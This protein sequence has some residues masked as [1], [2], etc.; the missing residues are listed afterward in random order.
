MSPRVLLQSQVLLT[1]LLAMAG[2]AVL[3]DGVATAG[4]TF[5]S[6]WGGVVVV[7][8]AAAVGVGELSG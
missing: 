5:C 1:T 3:V 6:T 7:V 8:A 4:M 2:M